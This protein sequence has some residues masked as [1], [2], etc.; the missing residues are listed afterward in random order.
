MAK[1][2]WSV[3]TDDMDHC[4]FS[5]SPVV[6]RHHIFGG[7]NRKRSEEYGYVVPLHPRLHPNGAQAGPG[8]QKI[9]LKLKQMA[10]KTSRNKR[11]FYHGIWKKLFVE[12]GKNPAFL[13]GGLT[14]IVTDNKKI[15]KM[16]EEGIKMSDIAAEMNVSIT[17]IF[18]RL[19][20]MGLTESKR[21]AKTRVTHLG[22]EQTFCPSHPNA[23]CDGFVFTHILV[24]EKSI[25]RYLEDDEIVH[26]IDE[27]KLNNDISNLY[28][29]DRAEHA[30]IHHSKK[31]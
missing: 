21:S 13:L 18:R 26:H 31:H 7:Y 6:E 14:M 1:K 22:Y 29:T 10:Q 8:W 4:Y 15:K 25:N 11:R 16:Y 20:S 12:A 9:D 19:R 27:N 28:L 24:I 23:N 17:T 2:L 3:F 5:K 30:R